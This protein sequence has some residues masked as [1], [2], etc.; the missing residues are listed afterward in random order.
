LSEDFHLCNDHSDLVLVDRFGNREL[1]LAKSEVPG[2]LDDDFRLLDPIPLPPRA[3][4]TVIPWPTAQAES[5][6]QT[7]SHY[8][9]QLT[10][11]ERRRITL[12]LDCDSPEFGVYPRDGGKAEQKGELVWPMFD[13]D[14]QNPTGVEPPLAMK[15]NHP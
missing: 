13:V 9:V 1:I 5:R 12:W 3:R 4:P 11:Q 14:P 8:D 2:N 15:P 10:A 6:A 7:S